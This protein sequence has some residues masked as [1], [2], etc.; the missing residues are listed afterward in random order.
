MI[1][2]GPRGAGILLFLDCPCGPAGAAAPARSAQVTCSAAS[3]RAPGDLWPGSQVLPRSVCAGKDQG[4]GRGGR[5]PPSA[6][7]PQ[8]RLLP[9]CPRAAFCLHATSYLLLPSPQPGQGASSDPWSGPWLL[10][11]PQSACLKPTPHSHSWSCGFDVRLKGCLFF[12]RG[13]FHELLMRERNK[14]I[15]KFLSRQ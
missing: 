9:P 8:S 6:S 5:E 1:P 4:A 15:C 11:L 13:A 3:F 12:P 7:T 10:P 14:A 2:E